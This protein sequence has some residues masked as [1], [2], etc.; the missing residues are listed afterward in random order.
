[1][2][3]QNVLLSKKQIV[4]YLLIRRGEYKNIHGKKD[5]RVCVCLFFFFF[6]KK[7]WKDE[8]DLT[9][10]GAQVWRRAVQKGQR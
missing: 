2:F 3:L 9:E 8:S 10:T 4:C 1:M 7:H 5:E 6:R